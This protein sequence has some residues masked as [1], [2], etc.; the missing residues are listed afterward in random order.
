MQDGNND[1]LKDNDFE[2]PAME[3]MRYIYKLIHS[4]FLEMIQIKIPGSNFSETLRKSKGNWLH[5]DKIL[6]FR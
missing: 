4:A 6:R 1:F 2:L 3:V 5:S